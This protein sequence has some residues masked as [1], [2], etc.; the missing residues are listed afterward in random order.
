MKKMKR[1]LSLIL[2]VAM[3]VGILPFTASAAE[4]E[5]LDAAI[6]CSDVH[7]N[8]STV[9]SV[10]NGI[11][12][13][14]ST[15][16]PSTASFV[17]DTQAT[18][19]S[20]T[21]AAKE[22]YSDVECIYAFGNHD[23]E[24]NYGIDDFTG[25]SYGDENSNYYV[26]TISENDMSRSN[27]DT[28]GFTSTVSGLD[29]SKPMFIISHMPLHERR[30]DNNGAAA[31]YEA[32][33]EAAEQMDIAFFWAHNHTGD[34]AVD[35]AAY[36]VAKDGSETFTVEGGSTV[37]PNFTYLNAGYIKPPNNA[38]RT[39]VAT[40]VRIYKN[41]INFTVYSSS[42]E[43]SGTYALNVDVAREFAATSEEPEVTLSSI[44]LSGDQE[45]TV[46]DEL[47]L[48]VTAAYSDGTTVDVTADAVLSG[49]DMSTAGT[50][51]VTVAYEG[52][53]ATYEITVKEEVSQ[54]PSYISV[55]GTTVYTVGDDLFFNGK[56]YYYIDG[57]ES[58]VEFDQSE[59]EVIPACPSSHTECTDI[60]SMMNIIAEGT[61]NDYH[62]VT[63]DYN[64][65]TYQYSF[66]VGEAVVLEDSENN[67]GVKVSVYDGVI[68]GITAIESTNTYVE[69]TMSN[70]H[71]SNYKAYDITPSNALSAGNYAKISLP[72]EESWN[73]SN[74]VAYY[75]SDD[76][77]TV[78]KINGEYANGYYTIR[79][80][81]F[82]T[83]VVGESTEITVPDPITQTVT[84][85][86][87][88]EN[89]EVYVLV[90]TPTAGNQ[91]LII[92]SNS[93]GNAYALKENTTTGSA[94]DI[95]AAGNGI[96]APY[97]VTT[98]KTIMW[99]ATSGMKF[100]SENGNYYLRQSQ[101]NGSRRLSFST[102]ETTN[103]TVGTNTLSYKGQK[104][105]YYVSGGSTWN[106]S[107]SATN[108]YFY[109]KQTVTVT[110]SANGTY[111]IIGN[112]AEI[113]KVVV[114]G[115][116]TT[117]GSTLTFVPE[118]GTTTTTDTSATA[119]YTVVNGGDPN[120]IISEISGNTVT[121]SG[122]YGKA[123]VKVSYTV[124]VNGTDYTVDNYITVTATEPIYNIEITETENDD[125]G[126]RVAGEII[127]ETIAIKGETAITAGYDLWAKLT[128]TDADGEEEKNIEVDKLT[129]SSNNTSIATVDDNGN[130]TFTGNEGS[131]QITVYYEYADGKNVTDTITFSVSKSQYTVPADGTNDFPE[132]P[133][134]GAIRFDKTATAVGNFSQTGIAQVELSMTGV[135]YGTSTKTDVVI[136]VDM[137][138][139]M[140]DDDVTAAESAVKELI[141]S[142]VYDEENDKYDS[143]IQLFVDVFYSASSDSSFSTEEYLNNVTI[144]NASELET[145]QNKIDFTQSSN[146]GGTRYNLA[147]KDV[148]ETLT[149]TGHADNQFVVFVSDGVP[150]AYAP[151][152]FDTD[153]TVSLG[154]TITGNNSETESLADGWFNLTTGAV[155]DSFETEYYSYMIKTAGIPIYTVGC[156]LTAL[157]EPAE[158]L[159]HMSSNYSADGK[160]S[161]G[162]TKY[163]FF[164]TT[165]GGITDK[166]LEIFSGIG[167]DIKE[168]ATNVM[169]EDKI[170]DEYTMTFSLPSEV[171]ADEAGMDDF[172][173][174]VLGY[175]L[176][177]NNERKEDPEVLEKFLFNSDGSITHTIGSTTCG[178]TCT[179]V[180][181][182]NGVVTAID[183]TYFDYSST[184]DG[185]LLTWTAE[186][187]D[188]TE[189][190]L[191]YFV[192]LDQSAGYEV[193][194]QIEAGTYP[195]NEYAT[196]TYTNFN[197]NECQQY[198]PVPSLT[199]NGAQVTYVFYL[200]NENGQPVNRAGKV[201]P[202][203]EA[204][205]VTD[206]VTY[207]VVWYGDNAVESLN[208]KYLAENIVP[209]VYALYDQNA[210]Y[211]VEVYQTEGVDNTG[212]DYNHFIIEGSASGTINSEAELTVTNL[213][214]T[215]VFNTKADAT[216]YSTYGAYANKTGT[217]TSAN[218]GTS[219]TVSNATTEIDYANTTVAFAVVWK[220][221]LAE[222]TVVIDYGLDV[223]IDVTTND[224][225]AAGVTG[226]MASAPSGITLNSG[227][228]ATAV[229]GSSFTSDDGIWTASKESLTSVRFH[230]NNMELSAPA[231]FYYEA[232]VNYYT[233]DASNATLNTT[234]MYSSVTVIPATTIYYEDE[235]LTLDSYTVDSNGNST[236]DTTSAWVLEGTTIDATQDQD[237][238]G[239]SKI[240][241]DIDADN[242]Y[243]YDSAY[244]NNMSTYSMGSAAKINVDADTR[245]EATF[246]FY[247]TG[248]DVIGMTSNTTGTLI[249]QV[250][251]GDEA[252]GTA[253]KTS[254]VDTY[255]GYAQNE[256][257]EWVV[258]ENSPN[259]LYQVPVIKIDDLE[260]GQYTAKII[261]GYNSYFD[262]TSGEGE[263]YDLYLDAIR[264]Y[265]PTGVVSGATTNQVVSDAY[266]ADSEGWPQYMELRDNIISAEG[267]TTTDEDG[268]VTVTFPEN[269]D[270]AGAIFIDSNDATTSI[271]DY[272][273]YGPNNE[274]YL[275]AG[276]SVAFNLDQ[277]SASIIADIQI[278]L[279]VGNGD[280]V[281]YKV[282]D[283]TKTAAQDAAAKTLTTESDLYYS[284]KDLA[285]GTVVITNTSGGI[286]SITNIKVTYTQN[287]YGTSTTEDDG[288]MLTSLYMDEASAEAAVMSL[289]AVSV[290]E[291]TPED[292]EPEVEE[293][294]PETSEPE[295]DESE[296]EDSKPGIHIPENVT[297]RFKDV[298]N[299][300]TNAFNKLFGKWFR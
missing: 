177:D 234:N 93:A 151:A 258:S 104:N 62:Q 201:I 158:V 200:V 161:T 69:T 107:S 208:A 57:K 135:P 197:G 182:T 74:L 34:N 230:L 118:S 215:K 140:S 65:A 269:T 191:Q 219:Y 47:K 4:G 56:A 33:S 2:C 274:L 203:A 241:A 228:Y 270:M 132:Y 131:V 43:Y 15:F 143:N 45:Y 285:S 70:A 139:S 42:G 50:Y 85:A 237:R 214:T 244:A 255:Y 268:E 84:G 157:T 185:E 153:G 71:V 61:S 289:R 251:E 180:T 128:Y 170:A 81:H 246:T 181:Y 7:G 210:Y 58:S 142:L 263:S 1:V 192:Y 53:E 160:T 207:D 293:S 110:T 212:V 189:L 37:T 196:I 253:V 162:E 63:V 233:Y 278:G 184:D 262:K 175:E 120:G 216:K 130:V 243:G 222:D 166:V 169:V 282:Y 31:W 122:N 18:A 286:L 275:K 294:K 92:S 112:P 117:L 287:P 259:A 288:I 277:N 80:S 32:I 264:I 165:S 224:A 126:N 238:P 51:T 298:I 227:T 9:T 90:S 218:S 44:T 284:I 125:D 174:Q 103:W 205:Y 76:G 101:S 68:S 221:E 152:S 159:A 179:H 231:K 199:W 123:L 167:Q 124:T 54:K 232:G 136:M 52:L 256:A 102:S 220:P 147:M 193:E 273:N 223:I 138:A 21:S 38:A 133:N 19:S 260:Y 190:A 245:G 35:Q 75:I 91:Y 29:K 127:K 14:D 183:G 95:N 114:N 194:D 72:V 254:V 99:N 195:T 229:G 202:F 113:S 281:T 173:I 250:Y 249:V 168:A 8:P 39:G 276:Q 242:N 266:V 154:T 252:T 108:V 94:V 121:F 226:V 22:V 271:V 144:S 78:E 292:S 88:T 247:G 116:T 290:E 12:S 79:V 100:Q 67:T 48:V 283:S 49:Y 89:K 279:K 137:T 10:F 17:G 119:T 82:S 272:V 150:T 66:T 155:T 295:E 178:D 134:Q 105:T 36:Y 26:Y 225:M 41:E 23:D 109:E 240:S 83:Y 171:T 239:A 148:Y 265:D 206:P 235:F 13:A 98:D 73:T 188:R 106:L 55:E 5:V 280:S 141:E 6:F 204:V 209:D 115:T 11:K 129:W 300:I 296:E 16:D 27:P 46:G 96:N 30:N 172:Y 25:L 176:D 299:K 213:E 64:G 257:G 87:T 149:R 187:L 28:S 198:F 111:S 211:E 297:D 86:T 291:S 97:I 261:A 3:V 20:V 24:G 146:G 186:K 217:Y 156:N 248:F 163:S 145:A 59:C 267:V 60:D 164:C 236:K 40:A 77:Q